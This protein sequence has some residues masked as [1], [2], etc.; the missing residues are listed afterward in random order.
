MWLHV[1]RAPPPPPSFAKPLAPSPQLSVAGRSTRSKVLNASQR[2]AYEAPPATFIVSAS[3]LNSKGLKA[4]CV[5]AHFDLFSKTVATEALTPSYIEPEVETLIHHLKEQLKN[6]CQL[7]RP[8]VSSSSVLTGK[9][10]LNPL[11]SVLA[12]WWS[13]KLK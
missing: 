13:L 2:A 10:Q 9:R 4:K 12:L 1:K 8:T 3:N 5:G 11:L 7:G 6:R